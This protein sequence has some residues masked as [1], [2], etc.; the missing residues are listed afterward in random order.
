MSKIALVLGAGKSGINACRLL[1]G[2]GYGIRLY[3]GNTGLD[4]KAL[5]ERLADVKDPVFVL[6]SLQP[7]D[8]E[9]AELCVI[10]PGIDLENEAVQAVR[11]AGIPIIGELELAW[12][13]DR[14]SVIAITGTNGKTTT[15]AL[16][17][18]I[19]EDAGKK[20]LTVGN[21]GI[22]Y[23]EEV[24]RSS[25]DSVSVAEVSSFQLETIDGFHPHISAILNITP[26]HLNRHK[27]MENYVN[28]KFDVTKNQTAEDFCILNYEDPYLQG[29]DQ[30]LAPKVLYFSS[31]RELAEG[32][33]LMGDDIMLSLGGKEELVVDI[34]E[35]NL[36]GRHNYENVMAAVLMAASF[37]IPMES[38]RKTL[39]K[40]TAVEHRIEFSGEKNGVRYY[41][42]SKGTN[43]DAAIQAIRAMVRPT[44]LIAGGYDKG[45]SF[46]EW[47]AACVGKVKHLILMGT[48]AKKIGETAA[49]YGITAITYVN[50]MEEAVATAKEKAQSG[51]A[52]LLSPACASWD[53][54]KS[55]EERGRIFKALI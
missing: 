20:T 21:I 45:G 40:F 33:W 6:G 18:Q 8:L 15:T 36:L 1:A 35:L 43:P 5:R 3:D 31:K 12:R 49:R 50:S 16:L 42:D 13:Y 7:A 26:D 51:D 32:A 48:T 39:K 19:M 41:N 34:H 9:G 11:A 55:Y 22:A 47:I 44:V 38:I 30:R 24:D 27:T 52:V 4:V 25:P 37:G 46:D 53:M 54:F 28:V 29:A 17:G 2:K 10:S 14:G 23:T